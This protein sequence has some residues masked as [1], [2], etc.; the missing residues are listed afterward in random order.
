MRAMRKLLLISYDFPPAITGVRRILKW[1]HYLPESGWEC[2]VLTVKPVRTARRD[3]SPLLE[4]KERGVPIS[5]SGSLDL[6]RLA[7]IFF[8]RREGDEKAGTH[9][10]GK[11]KSL[12]DFLRRWVFLPDDR[13]GWI[14]FAVARGF[15]LIRRL[16]PDAILTT[17]YPQSAHVAGLFLK[18]LTGIPWVAD[19]RDAWTQNDEFFRPPT[20]LHALLQRALEKWVARRCDLL[21]AVSEPI[22]AHFR[23]LLG[24][25]GQK[26]HTLTNGYDD[27]DFAGLTSHPSEK[28]S[29]VYTG[30]LFGERTPTPFIRALNVLLT[31][32]PEWRADFDV[33]FYSALDDSSFMEIRQ[34]HLEDVIHVEGLCSYRE[35]L[36]RQMDATILLI[37]IAPGP[38]AAVMMTQK[39][40]E[41]LRSGRHILAMIPEGACRSLLQQFEGVEIVHS[42]DIEGIK[43]RLKN[44]YLKWKSGLLS[45]PMRKGIEQY[46]RRNLTTRLAALLDKIN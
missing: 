44:L 32:H 28:F 14:P 16:K 42:A 43:L 4:L 8:R 7:E 19:F 20:P 25:S 23:G 30:S 33:R 36:Q 37:F 1:I 41:Y 9:A 18:L 39:V 31:E 38:N 5:R 45:V 17:S 3:S 35:S 21:L 27:A 15:R 40:F 29:L 10:T 6:Y 12:M 34:A 26:V 13:C 46:N 11:S 22:S 2:A 24:G